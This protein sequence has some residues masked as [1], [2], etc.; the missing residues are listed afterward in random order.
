MVGQHDANSATCASFRFDPNLPARLSNGCLDNIHAHAP[1][2]QV[3]YL[4]GSGKSRLKHQ[5]IN[6]AIRRMLGNIQSLCFSARKY[7]VFIESRAIICDANMQFVIRFSGLD[8]YLP[9]GWLAKS[10]P[11]IGHLYAMIQAVSQNMKQ[12]GG[13]YISDL[14]G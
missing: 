11:L 8:R 2:G 3:A 14:F 5:G 10:P 9:S 12:G 4:G 6:L 7:F 13:Q 1:S